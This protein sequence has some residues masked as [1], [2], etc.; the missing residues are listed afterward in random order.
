MLVTALEVNA[1]VPKMEVV[2][3]RLLHEERKLK[4]RMGTD[5][6]GAKAMAADQRSKRKGPKCYHC[7]KFGHIRRNCSELARTAERRSDS[8]RRERKI[9]KQKANK[10]EVRQRD[11]SSSEGESVGLV[12]RHA[13]SANVSSRRDNWIVDSGAT[14]HMCNDRELFA[15]L[16]DL[17]RP[18]EVTLGDGHELEATGSGTVEMEMKLPTGRTKRCKLRDVLYVPKLSYNLLSVSKATDAGKTVKF[19]EAGCQIVD[20]KQELVAVATKEGSLY[21]LDC[22]M[23][24]QQANAAEVR[25]EETREDVWHRRYGHLGV[26]NLQKLAKGKLVDGFDYDASKEINFCEACAEGKH[27]RCQFPTSGG[28]RSEELLGL[29]HSDVCGKMSA[30]SL[31]GAEYFLTFIDDKT[32][33]MWVYVLRRKNQV[34]EQ[35]LE[36]KALVKKSTGRK[37]KVLCTDNGGEYTSTEFERYLR[38]EGVRHEL[39]VPK[40]PEQNG[41][42]ERMNRTVVETVQ[43]MLADA[44]LPSKFWAEALSTAVYLRN[45]S[46][47]KAVDR[48]TP[49]EAWMGEKPKVDHLRIFGCAAYAHVAK[50]E[51]R[52]LDPKARKCIFLG[53]GTETKG[54]RLYDP[55]R[56]R[57]F[58]SRDVLFNES[59][60]G[61]EKE[62][63]EPETTRYVQIDLSNDTKNQQL[64]K[65]K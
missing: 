40:T 7:G 25:S 28:R 34:F 63:S 19:S 65:I 33:Y 11:S 12:V 30:Q 50:D 6:G 48:M 14:C 21:C 27:H 58:Y 8:G 10:V 3:E 16:R 36:W 15:E 55:E 26:R 60:G 61:V 62:P 46:P 43:S 56:R 1:E 9:V 17:E 38:S 54:Y 4:D 51:R 37:L 41:V 57:V 47:T 2:T 24:P 35:F 23:N 22:R 29:V 64:T 20:V 31:G 44:K 5:E 53:Y 45:R 39:A 59:K 52:K 42:A 18:L 13:L 32:R 49:F